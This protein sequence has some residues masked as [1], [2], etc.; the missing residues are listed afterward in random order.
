MLYL[1]DVFQCDETL[2]PR[3]DL[4]ERTKVDALLDWNGNTVRPTL[5]GSLRKIVFT[6]KFGGPEATDEE[7]KA[8]FE[9]VYGLYKELDG[10]L[11]NHAFLANDNLSIADVQIYNEFVLVQAVFKLEITD[12]PNLEKWKARMEEDTVIQE[13]NELMLGRLAEF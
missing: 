8:E 7:K 12:Y 1:L 5:T 3:T 2:L 11:S 4:K 6:P 10:I 9:K 13:L